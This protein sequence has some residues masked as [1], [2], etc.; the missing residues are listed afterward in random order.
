[1]GGHKYNSDDLLVIA[2]QR[3]AR[4]SAFIVLL[5]LCRLLLM[6]PLLPLR[7]SH[8]PYFMSVRI[9]YIFFCQLI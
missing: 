4:F 1:M 3:F 9:H 7:H 2:S 8:S 5:L 6:L